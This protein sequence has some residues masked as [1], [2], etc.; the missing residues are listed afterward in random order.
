MT[1]K[2][3]RTKKTQVFI[4]TGGHLQTWQHRDNGQCQFFQWELEKEKLIAQKQEFELLS[5][6]SIKNVFYYIS[7]EAP[8][9][10]IELEEKTTEEHMKFCFNFYLIYVEVLTIPNSP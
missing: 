4:R 2:Q 5:N 9:Y 3:K 1:L 10:L 7:F 6:K 8:N